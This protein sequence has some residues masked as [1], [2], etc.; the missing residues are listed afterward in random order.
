MP[1]GFWNRRI[2]LGIL[3][4]GRQWLGIETTRYSLKLFV[5]QTPNGRLRR[6]LLVAHD[7][8]QMLAE[9]FDF[10]FRILTKELYAWF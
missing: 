1:S 10:P 2:I 3:S 7:N 6:A 5:G 4:P 8:L 9:R